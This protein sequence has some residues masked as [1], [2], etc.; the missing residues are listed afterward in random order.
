[1]NERINGLIAEWLADEKK[2]SSEILKVIVHPIA[3]LP[4]HIKIQT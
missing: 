4:L 1:M 3:F 2:S